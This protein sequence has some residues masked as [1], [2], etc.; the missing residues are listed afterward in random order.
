MIRSSWSCNFVIYDFIT[1]NVLL[2]NHFYWSI[3]PCIQIIDVFLCFFYDHIG[4]QQ[5][6]DQIGNGHQRIQDVGYGP[7]QVQ[8][9]NR[10]NGSYRD[11]QHTIR[12]EAF[13][14]GKILY[15]PFPVIFIMLVTRTRPVI[16]HTTTVS[17]NVPVLETRA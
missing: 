12:D 13:F 8:G 11:V 5:Y 9:N 1:M 17:Q 10:S 4:K 2:I 15:A 16:R 7:Y 14:A 6:C 3:V